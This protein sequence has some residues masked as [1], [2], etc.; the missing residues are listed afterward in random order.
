MSNTLVLNSS[1]VTNQPNIFQYDFLNGAFIVKEGSEMCISG[2]TIPYSFYNIQQQYYNNTSFQYTFTEGAITTTYNVTLPNGYYSVNSINDYLQGQF[3]NQGLYLVDNL[4]NNVYYLSLVYNVSTY[5]VQLLSFAVPTSLPVGYTNPAGLVFP[6][7]NPA[8]PQ[9]IIL[10]NN[11]FGT[12]IGFTNGSYPPVIQA[13]NY[14]T[15]S[16]R[17]PNGSPVNSII[18]RCNLVSNNVISPS[19]ILDSFQIDAPFGTNINYSPNFEKWIKIKAGRYSSFTISFEDQ[20]FNTIPIID[21]NILIT[22]LLHTK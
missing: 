11:N 12:I 9:L 7:P 22:L 14:S 18:V 13:T 6:T 8:T 1:N 5:S 4:G 3:V 20:N 10:P 16:N 19:D 21:S 15:I 2:I 17:T